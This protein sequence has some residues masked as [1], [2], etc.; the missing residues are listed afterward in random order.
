MNNHYLSGNCW[1]FHTRSRASAVM[2]LST[3][4]QFSG[5]ESG[6]AFHETIPDKSS[7]LPF[8][9]I[10][11]RQAARAVPEAVWPVREW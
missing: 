9:T 2:H 5:G 8:E 6:I 10:D 1:N 4:R 11:P 3:V 7:G